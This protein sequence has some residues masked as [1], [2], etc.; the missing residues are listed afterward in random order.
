MA[1]GVGK[2]FPLKMNLIFFIAAC[3]VVFA[4]FFGTIDM[5]LTFPLNP[6]DLLD[7]AYL[8][9]FGGMM[10]VLDAPLNFKLILEA[11]GAICKY[12]RFLTRF[13][14]RGV[15]YVFLGTMTFGTL[16][17]TEWMFLAV[18]MGFFVFGVGAYS[19]VMGGFKSKKLE[20]LRRT[21]DTNY[22]AK[23]ETLYANYARNPNMGMTKP[24]FNEMASEVAGIVFDPEEQAC[25]YVALGNY[26][27]NAIYLDDLKEWVGGGMALM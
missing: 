3:C 17:R 20:R 8:L 4:G 26:S 19:A 9:V 13:T 23:L 18:M 27:Q 21:I 25:V 24:E 6:F 12:V 7:E 10:F 15:W 16:W 22:G 11:K 5:F 1:G 14:G 2:S